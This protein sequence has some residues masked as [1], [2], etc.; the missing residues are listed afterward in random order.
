MVIGS[1]LYE[2][3]KNFKEYKF[4]NNGNFSVDL[5]QLYPIFTVIRNE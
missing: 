2:K 4:K 3:T 5:K 1:D